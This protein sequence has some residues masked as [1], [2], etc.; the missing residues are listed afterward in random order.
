MDKY[1]L[2]PEKET[3]ELVEH[4]NN[5]I[6]MLNTLSEEQ[7]YFLSP[8][9]FFST[10][11]KFQKFIYNM[12]ELYALGGTSSQGYTPSLKHTFSDEKELHAFL[13]GKKEYI[14]YD[15]KINA[16]S[17]YIFDND[18]FDKLRMLQPI[19][20]NQLV[21]IRHHIA[22]ESNHS[23]NKIIQQHIINE[24]E[25]IS[26]FFVKKKKGSA[27]TYIVAIIKT[28]KEYSDYVINP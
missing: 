18:I 3:V 24:T 10:F 13:G 14:E 15:A 27:D 1:A 9:L 5:V 7:I 6:E 21:D 23:R 20:Y 16:L 8:Y 26:D 22:H 17:E 28:L 12:F 2:T 25:E 4:I 19:P 11:I